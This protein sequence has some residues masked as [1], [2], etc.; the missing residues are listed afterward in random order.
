M[1]AFAA[2]ALLLVAACS[3]G[4]SS[5][6][7]P[8]P[9]PSTPRPGVIAFAAHWPTDTIGVGCGE[10]VPPTCAGTATWLTFPRPGTQ[11]LDC[12]DPK[13][14]VCMELLGD[15]LR[16]RSAVPGFPLISAQTFPASALSI[17]AVVAATCRDPGCFIGPVIFDG[18]LDY[19]A[20]YLDAAA[21]GVR[22]RAYRP[23]VACELM[24]H[25]YAAGTAV[26]LRIDYDGSGYSYYV[27]GSLVPAPGCEGDPLRHDPRAAL[28]VGGV[29]GFVERLDVSVGK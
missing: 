8:G 1:R 6:P 28:F 18:E 19:A 27:N 2:L 20:I 15:R 22:V 23:A 10:D 21:D 26:A 25:H 3:S 13:P 16:F 4:S 5:P 9:Q 24:G 29:D 11:G 12:V 14:N 17:E 7:G